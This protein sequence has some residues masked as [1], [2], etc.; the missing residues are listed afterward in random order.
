[1][2]IYEWKTNRFLDLIVGAPDFPE[3]GQII[4]GNWKVMKV[5]KGGPKAVNTALVLTGKIWVEIQ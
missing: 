2:N 4:F 5:E 3:I 1:M